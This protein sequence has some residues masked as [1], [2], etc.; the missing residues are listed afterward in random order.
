M[1]LGRMEQHNKSVESV[2]PKGHS[3]RMELGE[4]WAP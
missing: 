3:V 2:T 1:G 4:G